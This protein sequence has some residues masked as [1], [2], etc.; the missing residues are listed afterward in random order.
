MYEGAVLGSVRGAEVPRHYGDPAAE[1]WA[2]RQGL[3]I[4][5]RSHRA[6]LLVRGRA[7]IAALQG[8][9]TGRMPSAPEA[10]RPGLVSARIEYSAVLTPKGRMV[11]DARVMWGP[12]PDEEGLLL[13]VP[14]AALEPLLAHLS[15]FVPP[16]LA[17]IEDVTAHSGLLT[18]LGP[19]AANTVAEIILGSASHAAEVEGLAEGDFLEVQEDEGREEGIEQGGVRVARV[20]D[21]DVPAWDIF[22]S[23]ARFKDV[24]DGF[25]Q[26]GAAPIGV[27]VWDALRVEAG[28]PAYGGDMDASTILSETGLV[29]RAVD[30]T[31]GCYTGQEV[32]VRIRDRGHVNRSL[33]GLLLSEG[34]APKLGAE[35]FQGE[36]VV[37][38][39]TSV[40][41]SPSR[42]GP[43][44]LGYAHREV[45]DDEEVRV[46]S[47][48]GPSATVR[49]LGPGWTSA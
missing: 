38:D 6:R 31:K 32:I 36:R 19:E 49:D 12:D 48:A 8:V 41:E 9:L 1:Y 3:A 16:R 46:G 17:S 43:I 44:G 34:P 30:H 18:V 29:D 25:V 26:A 23:A 40:V 22:V 27:G 42:A 10:L 39:I 37:G 21:V 5:D 24:W 4:R 28:R 35:L 47:P 13:D 11:A 20:G 2:A 33:R 15:R 14:A 45:L 7:P